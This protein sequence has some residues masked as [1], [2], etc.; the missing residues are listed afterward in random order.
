ME[1]VVR[2]NPWVP[3]VLLAVLAGAIPILGR[4]AR[5]GPP[6]EL[7]PFNM[8]EFSDDLP[9]VMAHVQRANARMAVLDELA[10]GRLTTLEAL[11]RFRALNLAWPMA[12]VLVFQ[13]QPHESAEVCLCRQ[14][15]TYC[16]ANFWDRPDASALV[17]RV[18]ADLQAHLRAVQS[19]VESGSLRST[20]IKLD[21]IPPEWEP[22]ARS[23][24]EAAPTQT[25]RGSPALEPERGL[26]GP[27]A[28]PTTHR[29]RG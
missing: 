22:A 12:N 7:S 19:P 27:T 1:F 14:L 21:E 15:L 17:K 3:L 13:R 11:D 2:R 10:E 4:A 9:Q 20:W 16:E 24:A 26:C 29:P 25:E 28:R 23:T 6:D 18:E 5:F 8:P